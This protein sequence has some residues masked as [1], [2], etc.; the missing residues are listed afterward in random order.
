MYGHDRIETPLYG[1]F[2]QQPPTLLTSLHL[3]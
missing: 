2:I 1:A 3:S